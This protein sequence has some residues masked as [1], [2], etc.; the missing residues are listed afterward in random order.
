MSHIMH[1]AI[2]KRILAAE[3]TCDISFNVFYKVSSWKGGLCALFI[4]SII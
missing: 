4:L 2:A 1:S 3:H